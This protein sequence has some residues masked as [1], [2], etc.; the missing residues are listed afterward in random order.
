LIF[1]ANP[2]Y[3]KE[4]RETDSLVTHASVRGWTIFKILSNE[5][6]ITYYKQIDKWLLFYLDLADFLNKNESKFQKERKQDLVAAKYFIHDRIDFIHW[7][8]KDSVYMANKFPC[9]DQMGNVMDLWDRYRDY[10]MA[11]H[12]NF[13]FSALY[14]GEKIIVWAENGHIAKRECRMATGCCAR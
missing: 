13:L 2:S 7:A 9:N 6:K 11:H 12:F 14:P 3:E 4:I 8:I 10:K 1:P 5:E